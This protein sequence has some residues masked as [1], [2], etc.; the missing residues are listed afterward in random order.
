MTDPTNIDPDY[1]ARNALRA[2]LQAL[3][4]RLSP[5]QTEAGPLHAL[6]Q[7]THRLSKRKNSLEAEIQVMIS[8]VQFDT[9]VK[10][11]CTFDPTLFRR[12]RPETRQV[13]LARLARMISPETTTS[14]ISPL[15]IVDLD[16]S[17]FGFHRR[18]EQPHTKVTPGAKVMFT[19]K[20]RKGNFYWIVS[21]QPLRPTERAMLSCEVLGDKW[22]LWDGRFWIRSDNGGVPE[23]GNR[24]SVVPHGNWVLP[25]T[26]SSALITSR[27]GCYA[28]RKPA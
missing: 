12:N 5:L 11:A 7:W 27:V 25:T 24:I 21:R 8:K 16:K 13:F 28:G 26:T 3:Q 23:A 18:R 4:N 17:I 10:S 19:R 22:T 14:T 15:N 20:R 6:R 2:N 1:T 9:P